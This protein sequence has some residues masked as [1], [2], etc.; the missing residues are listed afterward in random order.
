MREHPKFET[1]TPVSGRLNCFEFIKP[2][3]E[4]IDPTAKQQQRDESLRL[5]DMV[6]EFMRN[7]RAP[8]RNS[9][10]PSHNPQQRA[11][12]Y[13]YI[14]QLNLQDELEQRDRS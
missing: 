12:K 9:E 11:A 14:E 4:I 7:Y 5:E 1:W 6:K 2:Y 10:L 3:I 13:K 8:N